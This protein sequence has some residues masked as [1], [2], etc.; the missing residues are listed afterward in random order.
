MDISID[1]HFPVSTDDAV[2]LVNDEAFIRFKAHRG[3]SRLLQ[4]DLTAGADG[5]YTSA[6][7]RSVPSDQIPAQVR[8]FV[9]NE[10]ELRQTEAWA[11]PRNAPG[12]DRFGTVSV[13]I[14]G[15]PVR[16]TGAVRLTATSTGSVMSY[17]GEVRSSI[18]LF[19]AAVES[20]AAD[21]IVQ[22]LSSEE[23]AA[24]EWLGRDRPE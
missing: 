5:S 22:A 15:A 6:V 20:A 4:L 12:G 23:A 7:R 17:T 8:P 14:T 3:G 1:L 18:P 21:A 24:E 2:R 9:G 19:G 11:E 13:E 16:M 10:L